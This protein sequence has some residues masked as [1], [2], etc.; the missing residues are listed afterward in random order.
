MK[1]TKVK[2]GR[3]S[4]PLRTP[5]KTA[6]RTV[7]RVEDVIVELHTDT[8]AVGYGEAPPTGAVT[9]HTTGAILGAIQDHIAGA[10]LGRE[11]DA[12]E[13]LLQAVQGAVVGNSSAKAAVDMALWDLYGQLYR[14]P[15]YK[16]LGGGRRQLVTDITISVNDPQTMADDAV[17][18]VERGYDCLKM[19]VGVDPALDTQRLRAVRQAVGPDTVIRI[20][21]NQAWMPKQAV[22]IL[23]QMQEQG[24]MIELVEQPVK[25]HDLEGLRYVTQHSYVPV[26]ADEAVFSPE[27]A[28]TILQTR[29]ADLLNIKLMKCGGLY[30]ALKIASAAE[31][32]GVECMIG[33][34]LEAKISVNAAV[35]LAC[36]KS[37]ITK[38]DLDGP[39]LCSEDPIF[40]GAVFDERRIT[41][42]DGPGL[43]IL[44][45]QEDRLTP[46][47]ELSL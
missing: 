43:G 15:V 44:G 19:K 16:L 20:D 47:W 25:A 6:L 3:I 38:I 7:N 30:N 37:I 26:L 11:V 14:I 36:A 45:I 41:V 5:F 28:M 23:N 33:C 10:I 13:P 4:V 1:I 35:H 32:Y 29:A 40:G 17:K 8:G 46:I 27:D 18:A 12:F 42:S 2:L 31:V 39:V 34:M 22:A 24:L 21:A 9:G